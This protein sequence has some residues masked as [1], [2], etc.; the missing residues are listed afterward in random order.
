ML[1]KLV[2][3]RI[4]LAAVIAHQERTRRDVDHLGRRRAGVVRHLPSHRQ[5]AAIPVARND[6]EVGHSRRGSH[7]RDLAAAVVQLQGRGGHDAAGHLD[8]VRRGREVLKVRD[9][10]HIGALNR[11]NERKQH[12]RKQQLLHS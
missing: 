10:D 8:G 6:E 1:G 5:H 7:D 12:K 9:A 2:W 4:A 3:I 11:Q